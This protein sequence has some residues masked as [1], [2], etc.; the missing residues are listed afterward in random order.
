MITDVRTILL[1][2]LL[3]F[4]PELNV[5]V[6]RKVVTNLLTKLV[7][8]LIFYVVNILMIINVKPFLIT[9]QLI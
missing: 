6:M 3:N 2:P 5:I 8:G 7:Y 1:L 4:S 9:N